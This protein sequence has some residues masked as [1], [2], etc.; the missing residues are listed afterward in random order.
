M[1]EHVICREVTAKDREEVKRLWVECFDDTPAFVEWYFEKYYRDTYGI[2]I[3]DQKRLLASA[4]VVPYTIS[5]R[6]KKTEVGYI[7]GVDT[8]QEARHRGY[9]KKLLME[10]L[11]K[12]KREGRTISLLMP[13]EGQFYYR[14]GWPFCYFHQ[15]IKVHPS[16]LRCASKQYG[17]VTEEDL[18]E[19]QDLLAQIYRAYTSSYTGFVCRSQESWRFLLE[20]AAMEKSQCFL[21]TGENGAEAYCIVGNIQNQWMIREFAWTNADAKA[22]MLWFLQHWKSEHEILWLELPADDP[23]A[24]QLAVSKT[25]AVN[26]PFLMARIVDVKSCLEELSYPEEQIQINLKVTDSFASW[27]QNCFHLALH[28]GKMTVTETENDPDAAVTVE[29]LSQLVMGY[30][31]ADRLLRQGQIRLYRNEALPIMI[32]LWPKAETYIN[33]YY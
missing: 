7:V 28:N 27:N 18:F 10:C 3:F 20:D 29:T 17:C 21:L 26:Y 30:R 22:G 16:E 9:A 14:Y 31:A 2:G 15:Q 24:E 33:E 12:Q 8:T 1:T 5:L 19:K 6:G 25:A 32:K 11:Q 4:Q 13:F 23:L